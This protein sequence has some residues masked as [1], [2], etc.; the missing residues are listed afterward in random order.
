MKK[1]LAALTKI[2]NVIMIAAFAIMVICTFFQVVNRNFLKLPLPWLDEAS[3]Y[4]MIYMALIGTEVGLRD[5]SQ[6]AVTA[7]VDKLNG[8]FREV[9]Q[10]LAKIVVLIFSC[11]V[12]YSSI[13]LVSKQIA[14][15]QTSAA[16]RLPMAVPYAALVIAFAMIVLV[17]LYE[18]IYMIKDLVTGKSYQRY[19][20]TIA[21]ST[22][23]QDAAA[24]DEAGI[25]EGSP[26]GSSNPDTEDSNS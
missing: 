4:S 13:L 14:T 24:L 8:R 15:G 21:A 25:P 19:H 22:V 5:G 1:L 9:V 16:M 11:S 17:Q 20:D 12:L 18:T 26:E 23:S 2:E 10:I 7:V 3:T 6:I